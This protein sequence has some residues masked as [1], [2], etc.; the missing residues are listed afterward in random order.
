MNRTIVSIIL[1][2]IPSFLIS[3]DKSVAITM[4][5]LFFAF[6]DIDINKIEEANAS[7]L[8]SITNLDVPITVF[9]NEK[10]FIKSGETDTRLALFTRWIESP[11]VT[12]GNHTYSHKNYETTNK[13]DKEQ[14]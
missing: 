10:S 7:L 13:S 11:L 14:N 8:N 5:D 4:D 3:G 9:V 12:I 2:I 1:L 6:N